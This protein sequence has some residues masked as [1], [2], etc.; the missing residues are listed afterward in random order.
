MESGSNS[1]HQYICFKKRHKV[2]GKDN[3]KEGIVPGKHHF[4]HEVLD[5]HDP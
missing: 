5:V 1:S 2:D 4:I 3:M